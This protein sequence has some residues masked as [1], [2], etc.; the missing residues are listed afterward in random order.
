VVDVYVLGEG[1]GEV[2]GRRE[3]VVVV[4]MEEREKEGGGEEGGR[5]CGGEASRERWS[6]GEDCGGS[7]YRGSCCDSPCRCGPRR[8]PNSLEQHS[9]GACDVTLL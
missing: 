8:G 5:S 3:V 1:E 7:W 6:G 2:E 4:V 9:A